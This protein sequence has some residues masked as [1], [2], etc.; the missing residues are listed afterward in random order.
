MLQYILGLLLLL[1]PVALNAQKIVISGKALDY[2]RKEIS[3]YLIP[4]PVLRQKFEL[5]TTDVAP[6]GTFSIVLPVSETTEI[7]TDLEKYCGTMVVEPGK[8]YAVTLPPFSL[9]TAN[10]AHSAFFKP[11]LYWLGLPGTDRSDLNLSIRSFV[12][13]FN[14][15]TY[16]NSV[17]I[18]QKKSK[19]VVSEIITRLDQKY[20]TNQNAYFRTLEKYYFAELEYVV[21]QITP[22]Y[23]IK[24]YFATQP[25]QLHH[26]VYQR[27]FE[28]IFTDFLRRQ[29]QD[30]KNRKIINLTNSGNWLELVGFFENRDYKKEFAELVVLKGLNDGYYTGSFS[31]TG[32]IKAIDAAQAATTS[33]LLQPVAK[34]IKSALER[35]TAGG[36][37]PAINLSNL[38]KKA[39]SLGQLRGKF[40]YISFFNS[41]SSDCRT[42]LDSIVSLEKRLKQVL[43]FVSV[44]LDDDFYDASKLWKSKRY[45]W[46]LWNG[47]KQKQL[48]I[49]YNA[50]ITPVFCLIDPDGMIQLSQA[51][52]PSQGFEPLFLKIFRDYKF[53]QQRN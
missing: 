51:P 2:S 4:D 53:K 12:T 9:R 49:N 34:Q 42:E 3:F 16:K 50:S 1:I 29:S 36:K 8:K 17:Q 39:V 15:E 6:D 44:S 35:L 38:E 46:E 43:T 33:P 27:T 7:Y 22:E 18:Y 14:L 19:E 37:A 5:G 10:E 11:A 41:R 23:V 40:V 31:K 45:S 28:T 30:I 47:S 13:E 52:S 48:V 26:P 24:K 32:V 20:S 21:Y 25:V